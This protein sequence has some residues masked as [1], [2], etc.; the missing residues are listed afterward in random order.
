MTALFVSLYAD[1]PHFE[2]ELELIAE[3][4]D[5]GEDVVV[6]RCTG[7]LAACLKNP[8]HKRHVCQVCVSKIDAGLRTLARPQLRVETMREIAPD[9]RLPHTFA[10]A[11]ELKTYAL[12]G[13]E[14]GRGVYSTV[15]GHA[16]KDP[17]FDTQRWAA[18]IRRELEATYTAYIATRDAIAKYRADRVYVFNGRFATTHAVIVAAERAGVAFSTHERGGMPERYL[19]RDRALP[20]DLALNTAEIEA[21]WAAAPVDK[22]DIARR[23]FVERRNGVER[24]WPSFTKAQTFGLLPPAFD[25]RKHNIAVFNSTMEEYA[26]IPQWKSPLYD[27][28]VIGLRRITS[29]LARRPGTHVYLRVHPHLRGIARE[30]NYQLRAYAELER[31][32]P[33]L[34]VIWP[35]SPIHTYELVERCTIA[36]TFG[37]TVGAEACFWG[38]PS[39]L[40]GHALY[41]KLDCAYTPRDHDGV[42]KLLTTTPDAKP[43]LGA[44]RYGYWETVRGTPFRR[45]RPTGLYSGD[46]ID[47]PCKA[48]L[49]LRL[50]SAV[51]TR[52]GR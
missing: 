33:N 17:R 12:D 16:H 51:L 15:C 44:L 43:Q 5:R 13:A 42:M 10:S 34:S 37:S 41:E 35:E 46:W 38:T 29:D 39:V 21:V 8:A 32:V 31:R 25:A 45:F 11:E 36:L 50:Q 22:E 7:Q 49:P 23:W 52:L 2:T 9:P 20:H 19:L 3:L 6:L 27:D 18:T 4:L 48:S 30:D 40:A 1:T 14:L 28:E 24:A 47:G 26:S